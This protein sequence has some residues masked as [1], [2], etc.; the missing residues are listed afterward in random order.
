MS[1]PV[2]SVS[3][4]NQAVA[5]LLEQEFAWVTVEGEISNL[6]RP[7]SGHIYFSLKDHSAQVRCA[8]FRSRMRGLKFDPD[9]GMQVQ[10]RAKVSLY[11]PRGDYQLIVDRLE[12]AGAGRLQ[13]EFERLKRKLAAEGLFDEDAKQP[14]PEHASGIA[15]ITSRSGAAVRDVISVIRRRF[16]ATPV[17][18]YPVTV[19]GDGS[20]AE[21]EHA[22]ALADADEV[23]D[24]IL[25]V[26]GGGSIE[27]LWSFNE[28]RVARAIHACA[29]PVVSGV[30]HEIDFTIA[31]FV[32]DLRAATP[33]AAAEAVT[34]DQQTL[35]Q[36]LDGISEQLLRCMDDRLT[37]N[38]ERL[39]WL[40]QRLEHQHPLN[41][42]RR[43][44]QQVS[45]F[46][47]R[48]RVQME[49]SVRTQQARLRHQHDRLLLN[50]P[51]QRQRMLQQLLEHLR[52]DLSRL[53]QKRLAQNE[54]SLRRYESTL[55]ALSP[56]QTLARGYSITLDADGRTVTSHQ[57]L[58]P[59]QPLITRLHEGQVTSEVVST[60][61]GDDT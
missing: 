51:A 7:A 44:S 6:A 34:P 1:E 21:I 47:N 42:L 19:Q 45:G 13:Q 33:T 16:P 39:G 36:A 50:S 60:T 49:N 4:L 23:A 59:G 55:N 29:T 30:G 2:L 10:V 58:Q 12:E 56:L 17:H 14:V 8:I 20:A 26:R 11:Q 40:N 57:Q 43:M 54:A 38:S 52:A 53:M 28:E 24:V 18:L 5:E 32:A 9:N 35:F 27:D 25:L 48:M 37:Y 3:G 41:N 22:L 46:A 31:D 15:V 61:D